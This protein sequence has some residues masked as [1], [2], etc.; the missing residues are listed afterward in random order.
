[1]PNSLQTHDYLILTQEA[2]LVDIQISFR[3]GQL[4]ESTHDFQIISTAFVD[5]SLFF[6]K[7]FW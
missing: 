1:M 4:K 7:T 3:F 5:Y 2:T 6:K